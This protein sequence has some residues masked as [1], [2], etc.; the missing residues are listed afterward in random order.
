MGDDDQIKLGDSQDLLIYHDGN[1][2]YI[3]DAGVGSLLIRT[4]TNSNVS[5]KS[6]SNFMAKFMTA[7]AVELYYDGSKKF[8]TTSAGVSSGGTISD[9]KGD[10]RKVFKNE[11]TSTYTL[12]AADSGKAVG[13]E[14]TVT[15]PASVFSNG[16]LVTIYNNTSGNITLT[17]GS[18]LT[19]YFT[20]D[21]ST[22][23]RTLGARGM[24]TVY[25]PAG[26]TA[27]ISGSGL[28]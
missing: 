11:Q 12:V 22:G 20:G 13:A 23:N 14:N 8:E 26:T 27:F 19:M 1:D 7:D 16:D 10:V 17:Q 9:G 6:S 25:F 5:I 24:S 15:I 21:G 2:S 3:D 18:G 28:T 4:T